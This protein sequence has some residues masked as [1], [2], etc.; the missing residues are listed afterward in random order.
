MKSMLTM[1]ASVV[2]S[3]FGT[4]VP[5]RAAEPAR[6]LRIHM[7]SGSGEYKSEPSLTE[8]K[9]FVEEGYRV[10]CTLTLGKD[11]GAD[12]PGI[13]ALDRA[14][15]LV[16][17]CRRMKPPQE[18]LERVKKWCA[19]GKPVVGLRTASHAFQQ[20]LEFDKEV[21]GGDYR[22]HKGS[23][24]ISVTPVAAN[25]D[26]AILK[27]VQGW[28]TKHK[29]YKNPNIAENDVLLLSDPGQTPALPL[30]W[31]R[32]YHQPTGGR[33]FYSSLGAPADFENENFRKLLVS[34][35]FWTANRE[36][37]PK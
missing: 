29:T 8:F 7:I 1:A 27:G 4:I 10:E 15:V 33:S 3:L 5:A 34:A 19:A 35:I 24:D 17:F 37:T 11:G 16:V 28:T 12:L 2:L 18:Q 13:E 32:V 9:K 14:D 21:L 20:W 6:P 22:G 25:K 30:A 31:C 36:V 26:H 23:E